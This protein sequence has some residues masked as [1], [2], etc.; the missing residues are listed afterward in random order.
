MK[1]A[2]SAMMAM[3]DGH[4]DWEEACTLPPP[5]LTVPKNLAINKRKTVWNFM[6]LS[7]RVR[8]TREAFP[9][10]VFTLS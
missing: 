9:M 4:G 6:T 5:Q 1:N 8:L 3:L 2:D 7:I 10:S